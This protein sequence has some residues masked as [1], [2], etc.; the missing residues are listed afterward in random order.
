MAWFRMPRTRLLRR[1]PALTLLAALLAVLVTVTPPHGSAE[2]RAVQL[3]PA[4]V[5]ALSPALIVV[6]SEDGQSVLVQAGTGGQLGGQVFTNLKIGPS[7]NKGS[8]TMTFSD[9]LQSYVTSVPGFAA[10]QTLNATLNITTTQGLDSGELVFVRGFFQPGQRNTLVT[11]DGGL[12]LDAVNPGTFGADTYIAAA[13]S[14]GPPGAPPAGRRFVSRSYSVRASGA[15]PA[16]DLPMTLRLFFAPATLTPGEQASLAI[17]A[18]VALPGGQGR[19]EP[20]GG[21]VFPQLGYV[22]APVTRFT[23][24]ALTTAEQRVFLPLT[25]GT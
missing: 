12:Q 4:D 13:P 16:T 5:P 8:Y 7:G 22:S 25:E 1:R 9:P 18:W 15:L 23:F 19:W 14:Y 21:S 24:Y 10:A 3:A 11:D 6:P 17:H 20:A 2:Q